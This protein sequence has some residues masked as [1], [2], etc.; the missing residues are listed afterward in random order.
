MKTKKE[1]E[2]DIDFIGSQEKPLTEKEK[3]EISEF[4]KKMKRKKLIKRKKSGKETIN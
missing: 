2:L 3:K 4:I 1:I